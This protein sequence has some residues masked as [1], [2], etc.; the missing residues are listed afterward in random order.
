MLCQEEVDTWIYGWFFVEV[1]QSVFL[2]G[3]ESWVFTPHILLVLGSFHNRAA[4][5]ISGQM[6]QFWNGCWDYPPIGD[7]LAEAGMEPIVEYISCPH[8]SVS[9]YITTRQIFDIVVA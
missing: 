5:S 8:I 3:L 4:R 7:V 6:P 9:H 2:F 1:L